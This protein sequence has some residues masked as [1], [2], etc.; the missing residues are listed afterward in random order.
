MITKTYIALACCVL[1]LC[2]C[3]QDSS[4]LRDALIFHASFDESVDA[5]TA[6]GDAA[7]HTAISREESRLGNHRADVALAA[8]AGRFGGALSMGKKDRQYIYYEGYENMGY[9]SADWQGAYS[10]WMKLDPDEDLEPGYC[11][12]FQVTDK[13]PQNEAMFLEFSKDHTPRRLRLAACPT[14]KEWNT[15][16]GKWEELE[17]ADR[18]VVEVMDP[19]FSRDTWTHVVVTFENFNTGRPDGRACLYINGQPSGVISGWTQNYRW[20][21]AKAR[22]KIGWSYI[23]LMD[24]LAVFNRALTPEEVKRLYNAPKGLEGL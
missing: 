10:L 11:D 22:M 24:D 20:D 17:I 19:P 5:D 21:P 12:P 9:K 14:L 7:M 6:A 3:T 18:P 1:G 13:T 23:G 4:S 8:G 16:G 15:T 2:G